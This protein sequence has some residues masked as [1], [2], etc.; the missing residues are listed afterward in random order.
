VR[1]WVAQGDVRVVYV[2]T[3]QNPADMLTK[4]LEAGPFCRHR[5]ALSG[6]Q[7]AAAPSAA[8]VGGTEAGLDPLDL[9]EAYFQSSAE[10]VPDPTEGVAPL[11]PEGDSVAAFIAE[12]PHAPILRAL[13]DA[14]PGSFAPTFFATP[15]G[16][17]EP[18]LLSAEPIDFADD[19]PSL[20]KA[21]ASSER[22]EWE[23]SCIDEHRNLESHPATRHTA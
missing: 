12:S 22:D 11:L 14:A 8:H 4:S 3:D 21:A 23:E 7:P 1:E 2:P 20:R 16:A 9:W 6:E 5:D 19:Y 17:L 18:T 15:F 13:A 10:R